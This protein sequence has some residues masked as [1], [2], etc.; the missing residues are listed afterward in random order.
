MVEIKRLEKSEV[1]I[2]GEI[3]AEVF[4]SFWAKAVVNL[5]NSVKIDGFRSGHIPEDILIKNVGEGAVLDT[6][7]E[8]ALQKHYPKLIMENKIDAIGRPTITITKIAKGNPLGFKIVTAVIPEVT[9][10]DYKAISKKI[11]EEAS[12]KEIVVTDK[13]VDDLIDDIRRRRAHIKKKHI[14]SEDEAKELDSELPSF[15]DEFVKTLGEFADV[16]DFKEKMK[17]NL[18]LEKETSAKEA[19]RY[20]TIEA[21]NDKSEMELPEVLV[22]QELRKGISQMKL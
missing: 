7:A 10:P 20:K 22:E 16:A 17:K 13:E 14:H 5:G 1:E 9:L 15:D 11:F 4:A 12:S 8:M 6:A 19:T 18:K 21:I 3:S 2:N